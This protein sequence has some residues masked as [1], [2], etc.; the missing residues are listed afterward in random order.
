MQRPPALSIVMPVFNTGRMLLASVRSVVAQTLFAAVEPDFW[1]L[2]IVD[3]GSDDA[4]TSAAFDEAKALSP[5]VRV[6]SN[7][8]RRGVAGARNTGIFAAAGAWIAF[9]DS[10]D[11]WFPDFLARQRAAFEDLPGARWRAAHFQAG[12]PDRVFEPVPLERRSPVVYARIANDYRE[13]RVSRI[14]RPVELLLRGGCL[15]V[16]GVQVE[17]DLLRSVGGFNEGYRCAED[18]DLWLRLAVLED[19]HLAPHDAGIYRIRSGSLTRSDRPMYFDEDRMLRSL[20]KHRAFRRY[21][22]PLDERLRKVYSKFCYDYRERRRFANAATYA[23]KLV[24]T[25][26]LSRDGWRHLAATALLR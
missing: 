4:E 1:E 19:L 12:D 10:D 15:Q 26:P 21:R 23:L 20:R 7:A 16:M 5:R 11:V 17:R 2:L 22:R 13:G 14:E 24:R 8:R 6:M 25:A 3:D 18:Y 9:L